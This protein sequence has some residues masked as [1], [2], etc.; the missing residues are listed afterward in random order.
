MKINEFILAFGDITQKLITEYE[1]FKHLKGEQR[2]DR[3]VAL[4]NQWLNKAL[5][6]LAIN[7]VLKLAI[8]FLLP[9]VLPE[10]VQVVFNLI[11]TKVEGITK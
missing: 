5:K 3:V 8:K 11:Q 2:K 10:I 7:K 1:T 6:D 4:L 9:K